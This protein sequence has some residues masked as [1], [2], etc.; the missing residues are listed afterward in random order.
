MAAGLIGLILMLMG[1][2]SFVRGVTTLV[3]WYYPFPIAVAARVGLGIAGIA[4]AWTPTTS[5]AYLIIGGITLLLL[6]CVAP[7]PP[8]SQPDI[9]D[10]M[11][12]LVLG[13]GM[14][15]LGWLLPRITVKASTKPPRTHG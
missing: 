10:T 5:K 9:V 4:T 7:H 15:I 13:L 11:L 1:F 3:L 14:V 12:W 8:W 6:G 2:L